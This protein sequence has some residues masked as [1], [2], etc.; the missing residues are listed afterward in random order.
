MKT[1]FILCFLLFPI[2]TFAQKG[3]SLGRGILEID[4]RKFPTLEFHSDTLRPAGK[5]IRITKNKQGD[6]S[7]QDEK[8]NRTWFNPEGLWLDYSIFILRVDEKIGNWYRVYVDNKKG[9][10][11]WIKAGKTG[12]FMSWPEF[13]QTTTSVTKNKEFNLEIKSGPSDTSKT[14][15]NLEQSD[16]FEVLEIKGDWLK[17]QPNETFDCDES[18]HPIKS[19]WIKWNIK[20]RLSVDYGLSC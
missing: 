7:I 10:T 3:I 18:E 6:F 9:T 16:C 8:Q 20:N 14:I 11:L 4:F 12:N 1:R 2:L 17:V 13:L 19:G 5:K 15:R